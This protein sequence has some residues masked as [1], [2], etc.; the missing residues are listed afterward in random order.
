MYE[1]KEREKEK[2]YSKKSIIEALMA[3][4]NVS[5][6]Y[7]ELIIY[8]KRHAKSKECVKCGRKVSTFKWEFNGGIC[9][10]CIKTEIIKTKLYDRQDRD[11]E[12]NES[13]VY[14]NQPG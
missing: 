7:I 5:K 11:D 3:K 6:S 8:D 9:D 12:G 14:T 4:Y 13:Q 1:Y 2:K 10:E